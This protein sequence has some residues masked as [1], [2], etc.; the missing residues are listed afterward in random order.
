MMD[1]IE[2]L[3]R[4]TTGDRAGG[5]RIET[6]PPE[7][8][9]E[10]GSGRVRVHL[11]TIVATLRDVRGVATPGSEVRVRITSKQGEHGTDVRPPWDVRIFA[12]LEALRARARFQRA[13]PT[14]EVLDAFPAS[15]DAREAAARML[16]AMTPTDPDLVAARD[17]VVDALRATQARSA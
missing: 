13:V 9:T 5:L 15:R 16:E 8:I 17:E 6:L 4:E 14:A 2:T 7:S 10:T 11:W 1:E 12:V 3:L